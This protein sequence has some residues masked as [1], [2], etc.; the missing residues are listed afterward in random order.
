MS[1]I[2]WARIISLSF[3]TRLL[4][5][6][7]S[8]ARAAGEDT[9]TVSTWLRMPTASVYRLNAS[10]ATDGQAMRTRY[11]LSGVSRPARRR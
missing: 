9:R 1:A 2:T 8:V 11:S 6:I 5:C 4:R 10:P 3:F 7:I